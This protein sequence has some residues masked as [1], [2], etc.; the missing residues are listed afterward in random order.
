MIRELEGKRWGTRKRLYE[1]LRRTNNHLRNF[2][3]DGPAVTYI[4]RAVEEKMNRSMWKF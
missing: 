3:D 4:E 2:G 1:L